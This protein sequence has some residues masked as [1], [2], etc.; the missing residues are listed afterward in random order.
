MVHRPGPRNHRHTMS[1]T[2]EAPTEPAP[3]AHALPDPGEAVPRLARPT[4]A[5][6]CAALALFCA[7]TWVAIAEV[8][9]VPA[10]IAINA[11][12]CFVMFTVVH[13]A[14]HYSISTARWVN[15]V[16]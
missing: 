6:F 8:L 1:M 14:T 15:R 5:T 7:G 3:T 4:V 16:L 11:V 13:D 12:A 10:T 9:P 2:F